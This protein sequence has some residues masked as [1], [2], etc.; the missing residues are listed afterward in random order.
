MSELGVI[1]AIVSAVLGLAGVVYTAWKARQST[2][3]S[4]AAQLIEEALNQM[5]QTIDAQGKTLESHGKEIEGL[6]VQLAARDR[7]VR[8][9]VIFIDRVGLWL[10]GGM[11]G[12]KPRP[13]GILK[14]HIDTALWEESH[15]F[16]GD[17]PSQM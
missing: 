16:P 2:D 1:A 7:I 12:N 3:E 15:P 6:K 5:R 13:D 17:T 14:E 11:K 10:A 8:A 9:A 4:V